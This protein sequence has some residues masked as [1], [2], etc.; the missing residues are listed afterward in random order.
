MER[1]TIGWRKLIF[2][3]SLLSFP[4]DAHN[5]P[6]EWVLLSP[7]LQ[8]ERGKMSLW[9]TEWWRQGSNPGLA[10]L[11]PMFFALDQQLVNYGSLAQFGQLSVFG[12]GVLLGPQPCP[13][14]TGCPWLLWAT[15][16][17]PSHC[18]RDDMACK[19][20]RLYCLSLCRKSLPSSGTE[21][22][23]VEG[24]KKEA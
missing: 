3:N 11:E 9:V 10:L 4:F 19:A 2:I 7:L 18:D 24:M 22:G 13:F 12:S 23:V 14:L 16:A 1:K 8:Y 17:E 21:V 20:G 6:A 15:T 5:H